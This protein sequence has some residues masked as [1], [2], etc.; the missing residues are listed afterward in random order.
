M[1]TISLVPFQGLPQLSIAPSRGRSGSVRL[2]RMA[3]R[4][5]MV[6]GLSYWVFL[7]NQRI[8]WNTRG[9]NSCSA[10]CFGGRKLESDSLGIC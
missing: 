2:T 4:K 5:A 1:A 3:S 8:I 10:T 6:S 7:V 9:R